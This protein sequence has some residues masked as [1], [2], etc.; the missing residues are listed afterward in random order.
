MR[1]IKEIAASAVL[2]THR[3]MISLP[4]YIRR[5]DTQLHLPRLI[6]EAQSVACISPGGEY[7]ALYF[8]GLDH[9]AKSLEDDPGFD[10]FGRSLIRRQLPG[11]IAAY[12]NFEKETR[13]RPEIAAVPLERPMFVVGFGR[14]G[15]TLLHNLLALDQNVRTPRLWELLFPSPAPR[16]ETYGTDPR[17]ET[18]RRYLKFIGLM[19]PHV[20]D[21]HPMAA[22][23][24]DEC[25]WIMRH[26][27]HFLFRFEAPRYWY[28][29]KEL[30]PEKLRALYA[31]YRLQVQH[32]QLFYRG[33]RWVSKSLVHQFFAPVLQDVFPDA[34]L[35][36]LH[37]DPRKCIP[38]LASLSSKF[39]GVYYRKVDRQQLGQFMLEWFKLGSERMI[40]SDDRFGPRR[41]IDLA[42]EDLIRDPIASVRRIYAQFGYEYSSQFDEAMSVYVARQPLG[43]YR[44]GYS[45]GSFG[46]TDAEILAR[47]EAYRDWLKRRAVA[48]DNRQA[49]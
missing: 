42:Y 10:G 24:P 45:A 15:S 13:S 38:S 30:P 32:L 49:A 48:T 11:W 12:L 33:K 41:A 34:N 7:A 8:E 46:L 29:L 1:T 37:R 6:D 47:T 39:R 14:T 31:H 3:R 17:I 9:L 28:W 35:V 43:R 21:I 25:H 26:S 36:R 2:R 40:E 4:D 16:P 19:A 23:A 27:P 20:F 22:Q 5:A 44:H 18:T